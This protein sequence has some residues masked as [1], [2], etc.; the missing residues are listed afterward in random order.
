MSSRLD[1]PSASPTRSTAA[2]AIPIT[3]TS[4]SRYSCSEDLHRMPLLRPSQSLPSSIVSGILKSCVVGIPPFTRL[5]GLESRCLLSLSAPRSA[6]TLFISKVYRFGSLL[7]VS[8]KICWVSTACSGEHPSPPFDVP[9]SSPPISTF[10]VSPRYSPSPVMR[11]FVSNP[12]VLSLWAWPFHSCR[13]RTVKVTMRLTPNVRVCVKNFK[14][15]YG[16]IR[17]FVMRLLLYLSFMKIVSVD[18]PCLLTA[19]TSSSTEKSTLQPCLLSMKGDVFSGLLP[20]LCFSLLTGLLSCRAVCT[21]P[22]DAIENNLIVLVGEGCLSTSPCA[23]LTHSSFVLNSLSPSSEDLS[24]LVLS[25]SVL[26]A[27]LQRGC[28][29]PSCIASEQ[30]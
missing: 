10:G 11:M 25:I 16:F 13:I 7:W 15:S 1:L 24:D 17:V 23:F 30:G 12:R 3:H 8:E 18:S 29:I 6:T 2:S 27:F 5:S 26:Y 20:R 4:S 21:G 28:N 14:I 9:V 19:S 22:E